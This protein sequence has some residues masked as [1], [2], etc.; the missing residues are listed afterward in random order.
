MDTPTAAD[1]ADAAELFGL[2]ATPIRVQLLWL[3]AGEEHDVSSLAEAVG[4][5]VPNV[6]Q[7]LAKLRLAG[8]VG[9]SRRGRRQIYLVEDR[10]ALKLVRQA[11]AHAAHLAT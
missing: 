6:S 9:K 2:L 8:L 5:S 1:F 4:A 7:H 11:L 3:L 10:H